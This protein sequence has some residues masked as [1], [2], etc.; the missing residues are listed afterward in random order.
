MPR[1]SAPATAVVGA[2][3]LLASTAWA[4]SGA[5][6]LTGPVALAP[7]FVYLAWVVALSVALLRR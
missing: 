3:H 2:V 1:W 4:R 7:G 6:S 5:W